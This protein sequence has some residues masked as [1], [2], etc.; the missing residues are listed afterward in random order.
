MNAD[1]SFT[2]PE[3]GRV[4]L[5]ETQAA[6]QYDIVVGIARYD[7]LL[8]P[9]ADGRPE[10]FCEPFRAHGGQ[11]SMAVTERS[12]QKPPQRRRDL[13]WSDRTVDQSIRTVDQVVVLPNRAVLGLRRRLQRRWPDASVGLRPWRPRPARAGPLERRPGQ[14][15]H[16]VPA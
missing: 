1:I 6:Q 15:R 8:R 14:R 3:Y 10:G 12:G 16:P 5:T 13:P 11:E 9:V 2:D 7:D 4:G